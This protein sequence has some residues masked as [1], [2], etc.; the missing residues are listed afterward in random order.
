[1][2]RL[3][4]S[5]AL[6]VLTA[7]AAACSA[8]AIS[9]VDPG[10]TTPDTAT[11]NGDVDAGGGSTRDAGTADAQSDSSSSSAASLSDSGSA[12]AAACSI[13]ECSPTTLVATTQPIGLAVDETTVYWQTG[14]GKLMSA[15]VAGTGVSTLFAGGDAGAPGIDNSQLNDLV[16]NSTSAYFTVNASDSIY[17]QA[18]RLDGTGASTHDVYA[19]IEDRNQ[20]IALDA[21]AFYVARYYIDPQGGSCPDTLGIDVVPLNG[22]PTTNLRGACFLVRLTV[23]SSQNL[24]WTDRGRPPGNV[25]PSVM[26]QSV[27]AATPTKIA[28]AVNPYGIA[29]YGGNVYWSDSGNIVVLPIGATTSASVL[30]SS[31]NPQDIVVD[32]SG[33]YWIDSGSAVMMAPL[34]GGAATTIAQGQTNV[35]ALA[36]NSTS[37]FWADEGTYADGYAD[38]AVMRVAK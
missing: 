38:G 7:F 36:T 6:A 29:V 3:R 25:N 10:D 9:G 11:P 16:V 30:S 37:V 14:A 33:V 35:V 15:S 24:Y 32:S 17:A 12:E 4:A 22:S 27:S 1:L 19:T 2:G 8:P 13:G 26:M 18:V 28:S 23:D 34:G 20:A 5:Q 31:T 21:T